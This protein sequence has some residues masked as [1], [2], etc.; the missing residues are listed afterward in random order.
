MS[1]DLTKPSHLCSKRSQ[2]IEL[3]LQVLN[4]FTKRFWHVY[5]TDFAVI[6]I[7]YTDSLTPTLT[8]MDVA[9][10]RLE[11]NNAYRT[12]K[13]LIPFVFHFFWLPVVNSHEST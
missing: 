1:S 7:K 2:T 12:W 3:L 9:R 13:L 8:L 4:W 6:S 10:L 5:H 11:S